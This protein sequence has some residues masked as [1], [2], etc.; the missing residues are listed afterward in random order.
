MLVPDKDG[1]LQIQV[2]RCPTR[3][4]VVGD[5]LPGEQ[6]YDAYIAGWLLGACVRPDRPEILAVVARVGENY[7]LYPINLLRVRDV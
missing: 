2:F 6:G 7:E 1:D 4:P 5:D 3:T